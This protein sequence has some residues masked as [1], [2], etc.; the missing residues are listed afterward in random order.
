MRI[1]HLFM[2]VDAGRRAEALEALVRQAPQVRA[3]KG[4][5]AFVP[6]LD[7]TSDTDIGVL[8]EWASAD[9]FAAYTA[10]ADFA[11]IGC[12]LRPMM[13]GAPVSRRFDAELVQTVN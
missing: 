9:D 10:S 3:M 11:A 5:L 12:L 13:T 1:T 4:C 8:H 6:F 2:S 7:P